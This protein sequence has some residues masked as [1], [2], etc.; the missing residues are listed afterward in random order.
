MGKVT[1]FGK[2]ETR[3]LCGGREGAAWCFTLAGGRRERERYLHV[4]EQAMWFRDRADI[5]LQVAMVFRDRGN[6]AG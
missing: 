3:K 5:S 4:Y 2:L 1:R 6:K